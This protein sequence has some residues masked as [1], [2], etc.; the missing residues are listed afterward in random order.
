MARI[1]LIDENTMTRDQRAAFDLL[2]SNLARGLVNT[3]PRVVAAKFRLAST[4]AASGLDPQL[5]ELVMMRVAALCDS[6]YERLQHRHKAIATGLTDAEL[7]A[8]EAG[9]QTQLDP[10]KATTLRF[11]DDCYYRTKVS[12]PVLAA[13]RSQVSDSDL[14][15][16]ILI[17]GSQ[18]QTARF[19]ETLEIDLDEAP[20]NWDALDRPS[21]DDDV[22]AATLKLVGAYQTLLAEKRW[23]EWID[24]WAEDAEL[25]FPFAP[26]G[27]KS[28][29]RGRAE[30]LGYMSAV[31]RVVVDSLDTAR[32]F[33]AQEPNVAVVEFTVTG[34]APATGAP[35]NQ[36][37][38]I[39]F[40]TKKGKIWR[41]RE[42][43]NPLV[44]IDAV[45]DLE[46]W[47]NGFG[48]PDPARD[49]WGS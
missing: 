12:E 6:D 36:S 27:R 31:G 28:V 45:G 25:S 7:S 29:Y 39:F 49:A 2:P 30:I 9:D 24:L 33:P 22:R 15:V 38:V 20:A 47:T 19:V 48:S 21:A 43:W 16:I 14:V 34:H 1:N 35:Y 41:Y 3:D 40:E 11:V 26:L 8:I 10:R 46:T 5:R 4:Y 42:Y 23:D 37:F 32:L 44:T 13:A 17:I 18:M